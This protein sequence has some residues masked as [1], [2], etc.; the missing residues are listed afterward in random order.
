MCHNLVL[1]ALRRKMTGCCSHR[2]GSTQ[3]AGGQPGLPRPLLLRERAVGR[4]HPDGLHPQHH[5]V[6]IGD[7]IQRAHESPEYEPAPTSQMVRTRRC[8]SLPAAM[9][10]DSQVSTCPPQTHP[11]MS[12]KILSKVVDQPLPLSIV[13]K[14]SYYL[15]VTSRNRRHVVR[16][17]KALEIKM[18]AR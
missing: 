16:G 7:S 11:H 6:R 10:G 12:T 13:R 17:K 8:V 2:S 14:T 15:C 9:V 18:Q 3:Q 4:G 1:F 5:S